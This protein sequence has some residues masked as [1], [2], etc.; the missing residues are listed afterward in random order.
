MIKLIKFYIKFLQL[1]SPKLAGSQAFELFQITNK[2]T[3]RE[4]EM[5]FY[6]DFKT[7]MLQDDQEKFPVI[8][9]KLDSKQK[10]VLVH[11]WNSNLAS[12]QEQAKALHNAGICFYAFNLPAH[13]KSRLKKTNIYACKERFKRVVDCI[14]DKSHLSFISHSFGS[15]VTTYGLSEMQVKAESLVFLSVPESVEM[16]FK[17]LAEMFGLND[18]ALK[19]VYRLGSE[20]AKE[21]IRDVRVAK[22][23]AKVNYNKLLIIHDKYD[24]VIPFSNSENISS[25]AENA[26]LIAYEKIGHYRMLTNKDVLENTMNFVQKL[27][28]KV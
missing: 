22:K 13:G 9:N 3:I 11:G 23:L 18:S 7:I 20:L 1:L 4:R 16:M 12:L 2:K 19:E 6:D 24:K 26:E 8:T 25:T 10:V 5:K 14:D 28:T 21:D 27:E 15:A 17:E